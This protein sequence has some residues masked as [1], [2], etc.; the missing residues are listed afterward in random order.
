MV[1][2]R[3]YVFYHNKEENSVP[4]PKISDSIALAR[5]GPEDLSF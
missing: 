3:L 5:V 1:S 4:T 2:F